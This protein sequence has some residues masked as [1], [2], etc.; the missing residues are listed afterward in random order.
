MTRWRSGP[1]RKAWSPRP[2]LTGGR[3][4]VTD[5]T[6][7]SRTQLMDLKTLDWD[8]GMLAAFD[9]PRSVLLRI[10]S[11]SEVYA[12]A[13]GVLPGVKVSGILGDQQAALV[14]QACFAP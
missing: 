8:E 1:I 3:A 7:A 11:S 10:C 12:Q 4:H 14:G 13:D 2:C 5:V 6:N 9:I